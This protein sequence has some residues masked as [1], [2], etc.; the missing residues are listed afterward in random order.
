MTQSPHWQDAAAKDAEENE[1][2]FKVPD[3]STA[4]LAGLVIVAFVTGRISADFNPD[5]TDAVWWSGFLQNFSTEM[6]GAIITFGLFEL[7]LNRRKEIE[8]KT[9]L[10]ARQKR[11]LQILVGSK[12]NAVAIGALDELRAEGWLE[13]VLQDDNTIIRGANW[14]NAYLPKIELPDKNM[15]NINLKNAYLEKANF[16][17]ANLNNANLEG[18][19]M[20]EAQLSDARLMNTRLEGVDLSKARLNRTILRMA[21]L[22]G[23]NLRKAQLVGASLSFA[24]LVDADLSKAELTDAYLDSAQLVGV[25]L[26]GAKINMSDLED[27]QIVGAMMIGAQIQR[28]KMWDTQFANTDLRKTH[29][30]GADLMGAQLTGTDL[31]EVSF[32]YSSL[33]GTNFENANMYGVQCDG[34]TTLPDRTKWTES[35]D[36]SKF[37]AIVEKDREKW[38]IY[39]HNHRLPI[40]HYFWNDESMN[41]WLREQG[42]E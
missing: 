25:K 1:K 7:I 3:L 40:R 36:W 12:N 26:S 4:I 39:R 20:I 42:L 41:D 6:M 28:T 14:E 16:E 34:N 9:S 27:A 30:V 19:K 37:G 10:E 31:R 29:F 32:E 21:R 11:R 8:S 35:I 13:E 22:T 5:F 18:A 15:Q 24:Q 23:A 17:R 33:I 38:L 2:R